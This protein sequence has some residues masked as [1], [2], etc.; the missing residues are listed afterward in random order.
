[1]RTKTIEIDARSVKI[2]PSQ[3]VWRFD[4]SK[5][6]RLTKKISL[7]EGQ[8]F[9]KRL[10]VAEYIVIKYPGIILYSALVDKEKR[11]YFSIELPESYQD[12]NG[13]SAYLHQAA[14]DYD[15]MVKHN[16]PLPSSSNAPKGAV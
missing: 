10:C 3:H 2:E 5:K 7:K 11:F 16:I 15:Y 6:P 14:L 8:R 12:I 1:M 9:R 13:E 4:G